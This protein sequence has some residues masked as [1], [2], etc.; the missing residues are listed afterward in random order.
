M[1]TNAI[2]KI[3]I[4]S[5]IAIAAVVSPLFLWK[6][7][8][9]GTQVERFGFFQAS[10]NATG[11][12]DNPYTELE[13]EAELERPDGSTWS[14]PLFW[15]GGDNWNLR[16]SPDVAGEWSFQI[17]SKDQ[18][19]DGGR[20]AFECVPS[21]QR[22][23][24]KPMADSPYHFE[25]QNGDRVWFMGDTAWALFTDNTE[26]KHDRAAVEGYLR[27]RADEGFNVVH[28]MVLS[29]AGWGNVGGLPFHDMSTQ[30]INPAYWREMDNRLEYANSQ[31]IVV[32]LVIA[33]ADK[34]K[35]EPFAWRKFPGV[36]ARKRYARYVASRY[37]A[38]DVYFLVSGEWH[39]EVRTR[40]STEAEMKKEFIEIGDTLAA[41]DAHD[42]MIGIHPMTRHGSV[43]EF[44][45][46]GWM[47]FGDYQQNYRDLH[48]RLLRSRNF[49][50]PVVNSEYGYY[51]RDRDGD[52]TPDKDNSTSLESIR[53][54]SWDIVMAGGYLVTGFG[55]TYFGGHRDP[56][57]F[58]VGAT[59][60]E[61]WEE[62]IELM[63]K[64]FVS[65]DWWRLEPHDELLSCA[66]Q[67]DND[68]NELNRR[69]PPKVTYWCLAEPGHQYMVY[70]RGLNA[71]VTLNVEDSANSWQLQEFNPRNGKFKQRDAE[72]AEGKFRYHPINR[73]DWIFF[74]AAKPDR[75]KLSGVGQALLEDA[76]SR[77]INAKRR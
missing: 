72:L 48:A 54:A 27:A 25:F 60:N 45:E 75:K 11:Q 46:A 33:W 52:G 22:G 2:S 23:S 62:Q 28:S 39:G 16:V 55:T 38:Y 61:Q 64:A 44:N 1:K 58:D 29:E 74:L 5:R 34:R 77:K 13:A 49:G 12:Y 66:T 35:Q 17:R 30:T 67:R 59:K 50:K 4:A 65:R 41:S 76:L 18:G 31:G 40:P 14:L 19:L 47:S 51:L 69:S 21:N 73:D 57:P 37:G 36:E 70:G 10:F 3:H 15:D 43:R 9:A 7:A 32:G 56:G 6:N 8:A 53:H 68:S 20:G 42:R 24:L 26:E 71:P 63:K